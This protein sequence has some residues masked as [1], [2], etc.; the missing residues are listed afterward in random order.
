MFNKKLIVQ[1]IRNMPNQMPSDD[2]ATEI[3][4]YFKTVIG[5]KLKKRSLKIGTQLTIGGKKISW[6]TDDQ[7]SPHKKAVGTEHEIEQEL[8][9]EFF[10]L[11]FIGKSGWIEKNLKMLQGLSDGELWRKFDNKAMSILRHSLPKSH[12]EEIDEER[13]ERM[14]LKTEVPLDEIEI[15]FEGAIRTKEV[16]GKEVSG[17]MAAEDKVVKALGVIDRSM[18]P[19][20]KKLERHMDALIDKLMQSDIEEI[21]DFKEFYDTIRRKFYDQPQTFIRH[22]QDKFKDQTLISRYLIN[23]FPSEECFRAIYDKEGFLKEL[24]LK[25]GK[26]WET[27]LAKIAVKE[28][29]KKK[30]KSGMSSQSKQ[31]A[32]RE[33]KEFYRKW[34]PDIN[35]QHILRYA[36]SEIKKEPQDLNKILQNFAHL[37]YEHMLRAN[38]NGEND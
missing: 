15:V 12:M 4:L 20:K 5:Q 35:S 19:M 7:L 6:S 13:P 37:L 34:L 24:L 18:E 11:E 29:A 22:L 9:M 10:S 32:V 27:I 25:H 16:D 23:T 14:W 33:I 28:E 30:L 2:E 1:A 36:K 26:E 3:M 21:P 17:L 8:F 31:L 38:Q